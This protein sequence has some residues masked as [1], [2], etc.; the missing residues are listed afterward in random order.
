MTRMRLLGAVAA[1]AIIA[2]AA[3][4]APYNAD[5]TYRKLV[6]DRKSVV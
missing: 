4:Q 3:A 1:A 2:P 5:T 6:R